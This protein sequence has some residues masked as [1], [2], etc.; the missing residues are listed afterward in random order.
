[1]AHGQ[2]LMFFLLKEK[3]RPTCLL[4]HFVE[5]QF[6]ADI[7]TVKFLITEVV[8]PSSVEEMLDKHSGNQRLDSALKPNLFLR[9]FPEIQIEILSSLPCKQG[10]VTQPAVGFEMYG[11]YE[12]I[13]SKIQERFPFFS[14]MLSLPNKTC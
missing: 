12:I 5:L 14:F 11:P 10:L 8:R 3:V 2:R 1:M 7:S 6:M 13:Y 4:F 9:H